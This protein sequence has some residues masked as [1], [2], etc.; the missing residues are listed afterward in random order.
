[1][2]GILNLFMY[3]VNT[4]AYTCRFSLYLAED[5]VYTYWKVEFFNRVWKNIYCL[6][7]EL[8]IIDL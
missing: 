3:N 8:C 7:Q 5:T 4:Y 2:C 6:L 1:M